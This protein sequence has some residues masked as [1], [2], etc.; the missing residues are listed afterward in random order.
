MI[1]ITVANPEEHAQ[2]IRDLFWEYL[3][4]AN[5]KVEENFGVSFDIAAMLKDDMNTLDKFMPPK[6][7]LLLGYIDAQP[8]GIA[9]LKTLTD[10]IGEIKRMYVRPQARNR[11][12]GRRLLNQLL[13]EAR[14]IGYER[15]RL[16]SARFRA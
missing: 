7:R 1:Q 5:K 16:D 3:Q 2:P 11:G 13:E 6:G 4:W 8:M 14:Q 10:S 15:V 9:C 12:L